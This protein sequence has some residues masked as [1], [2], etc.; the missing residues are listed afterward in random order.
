LHT[1]K[2]R[3]KIPSWEFQDP[4]FKA[5]MPPPGLFLTFFFL[6]PNITKSYYVPFTAWSDGD[7][8]GEDATSDWPLEA[9]Y[10]HPGVTMRVVDEVVAKWT[11]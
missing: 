3:H 6:Y 5:Q 8:D 9:Y 1:R 10:H 7:P 11:M 2:P 4:V